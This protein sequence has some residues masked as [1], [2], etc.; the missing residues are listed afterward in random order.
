[1]SKRES[2]SMVKALVAMGLIKLCTTTR[3]VNGSPREYIEGFS[4][5]GG[6]MKRINPRSMPK[7]EAGRAGSGIMEALNRQVDSMSAHQ[8][9]AWMAA[10]IRAKTEQISSDSDPAT[11]LSAT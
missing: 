3:D 8:K 2:I 10:F 11:D 5:A 9:L 7:F 6:P 4:V 1:M